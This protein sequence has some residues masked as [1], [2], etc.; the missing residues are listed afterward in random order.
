MNPVELAGV[1]AKLGITGI[2]PTKLSA[3]MTLV[4]ALGGQVSVDPEA[5]KSYY[6]DVDEESFYLPSHVPSNFYY[7]AKGLRDAGRVGN[8]RSLTSVSS[9]VFRKLLGMKE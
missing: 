9:S 5:V 4:E 8:M 7:D 1:L 6:P 3:A 2:D